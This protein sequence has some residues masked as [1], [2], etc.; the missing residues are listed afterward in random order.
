MSAPEPVRPQGVPA[1]AIWNEDERVWEVVG[2]DEGRRHGESRTYR[3]DGTLAQVRRFTRGALDGP[4]TSYHPG[5][6]VS[7]RGTFANGALVGAYVALA[8][9][10][11]MGEGLRA[12]CVPENAWELRAQYLRG[13]PLFERFYDRQGWPLL[14]SG[15]PRPP[16]PAGVPPDA[17]F[18]EFSDRWMAGRFNE[19]GHP[20]GTFRF[21]AGD[22]TLV[23]ERDFRD[24]LAVSERQYGPDGTLTESYGWLDH[25]GR[26]ARHGATFRRFDAAANPYADPRVREERGAYDQGRPCGVWTLHDEQGALLHE[27]ALGPV[28]NAA[29]LAMSPAFEE[30]S[31]DAEPGTAWLARAQALHDEG[32][33]REALCAAA[34]AAAGRANVEELRA[35]LHRWT[36]PLDAGAR[37]ERAQA[38]AGA[39]TTALDAL[40]AL[41]AGAD[42]AAAFRALAGVLDPGT[43][44]ALDFA[45]AAVL[46]EPGDAKAHLTRAFIRIEHGDDRGARADADVVAAADPPAAQALRVQLA[47][48]FPT[49][50]FWPAREP[51]VDDPE[52]PAQQPEQSLEAIRHVVQVY[53]TR[54]HRRRIE[55]QTRLAAAGRGGE[56][57]AWLPPDLRATLLLRGPIPLRRFD[58]TVPM[59]SET[60]ETE[61]IEVHVD[62]DLPAEKLAGATVPELLE[63]ARGEW[64]AL[65]WLCWSCGLTRAELPDKLVP[66]PSFTAAVARAVSRCFAAHDK[67][68][69][70]GVRAR[71]QGIPSFTWEGISLDQLPNHLAAVAAAEYLELRSMFLWLA[72]DDSVSPFQ[73]DLREA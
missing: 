22:G 50:D 15:S 20:Q 9:D 65:T 7:R 33:T 47:Q 68:L 28:V 16:A 69:T 13:R 5:G 49:F 61:L 37:N 51:L 36:L 21:W 70:G 58:V 4:F 10:G 62:E 19:V 71:M 53:A 35:R 42:A 17:D 34:R 23:E 46:L 60:G 57:P 43:R 12:C 26:G 14:D 8:S 54:L 44:A 48:R 55:L 30:L 11:G 24:G 3:A 1:G 73:D 2:L 41:V 66:P 38:L 40:D 6:D 67:V 27:R 31:P 56:A 63:Q 25:E 52:V 72:L 32:R 64:A 59:E 39:A 45:D 29:D 18:D